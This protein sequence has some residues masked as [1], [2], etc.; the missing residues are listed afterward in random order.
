MKARIFKD[1]Y[2]NAN[3]ICE[4]HQIC[5]LTHI[6]NSSN[7]NMSLMTQRYNLVQ[8][9]MVETIKKHRGIEEQKIIENCSIKLTEQEKLKI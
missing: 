8:R 9:V 2:E 1:Q 5:N 4:N 3:F 6:L 7:A